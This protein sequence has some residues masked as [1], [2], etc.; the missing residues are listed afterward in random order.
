LRVRALP[1]VL[2][3]AH[4]TAQHDPSPFEEHC[5]NEA[6]NAGY[7][8]GISLATVLICDHDNETTAKLQD[9][10]AKVTLRAATGRCVVCDSPSAQE[11]PPRVPGRPAIWL[12]RRDLD[13][14]LKVYL[15]WP[16]DPLTNPRD[17][18]EPM[19]AAGLLYGL[20]LTA[21]MVRLPSD[22]GDAARRAFWQRLA[23]RVKHE[24]CTLCPGLIHTWGGGGGP[25]VVRIC[26]RCQ[27]YLRERR[28]LLQWSAPGTRAPEPE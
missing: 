28:A 25:G 12:C 19:W 10:E 13:D 7:E 17:D 6:W 27:A 15:P 26:Y 23:W 3:M 16:G 22:D 21:P 11:F 14:I 9:L 5:E 18:D 8:Y 1:G 2:L 20:A 24:T 4:D